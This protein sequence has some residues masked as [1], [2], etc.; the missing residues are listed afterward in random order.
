MHSDDHTKFESSGDLRSFGRR[1]GRTLS[2]RQQTLIRD[3]LPGYALD[4]SQPAPHPLT[5]LF[6][7]PVTSV[8]LEIGF[9]AAEH[10]IWQAEQN[11]NIGIIGCEPYIDGVVKAVSAAEQKTLQNLALHGDDARD[12]LRWLPPQSLDNVF[13]LFPDPWPKTRHRKRRLVNPVMFE[14]LA[15]VMRPGAPL[16]IATDIDDYAKTIM[17]AASRAYESFQWTAQSSADWRTRPGVWPKTRYEQKAAREGRRA[18]FLNF[19][20]RDS[21]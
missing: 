12:V 16:T 5:G 15:S 20:R 9:G 14:L 11:P 3:A 18:Y 7:V 1:H 19:V 8:W 10:L 21:A 4:L 6:K 13:I 17:F 2:P